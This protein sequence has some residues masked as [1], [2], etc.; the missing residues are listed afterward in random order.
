MLWE[1]DWNTLNA[2]RIFRIHTRGVR[3]DVNTVLIIILVFIQIFTFSFSVWLYHIHNFY[4]SLIEVHPTGHNH[5]L[6]EV[7]LSFLST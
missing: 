1:I 3:P 5:N 6:P 4:F 7:P 2:T